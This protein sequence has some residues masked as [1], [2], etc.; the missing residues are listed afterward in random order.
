MK[1]LGEKCY[2]VQT[3]ES[4]AA[5]LI[6]EKEETIINISSS[7]KIIQQ[8][9][10]LYDCHFVATAEEIADKFDI[11]SEKIFSQFNVEQK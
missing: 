2:M 7:E 3:S 4:I 6:I 10:I 1:D 8:I 11:V 9:K 5:F